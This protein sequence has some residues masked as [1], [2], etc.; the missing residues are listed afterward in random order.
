M[1]KIVKD[2]I[3]SVLFVLLF[4]LSLFAFVVVA[5]YFI[6]KT[7]HADVTQNLRACT[8]RVEKAT[9]S[10]V[11]GKSGQRYILTNWHVCQLFR[12]KQ[13]SLEA[14]YDDDTTVFGPI[15]VSDSSVDLCA[16]KITDQVPALQMTPHNRV[17][18][19][20]TRGYPGGLVNESHGYTKERIVWSY[21]LA[22][23]LIGTCPENSKVNYYQ[24]GKVRS[25]TFT[26][27]NILTNLYS[28]PGSSG[29][30]VLDNEGFLAGVISSH[31]SNLS[32][33][34]G[35]MVPTEDVRAFLDKL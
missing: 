18:D 8:V 26:W 12:A 24:N 21:E 29:S 23:E 5:S 17:K 22:V 33:F 1:K 25:C 2:A 15:V 16:A 28:R 10:I 9:G 30:P 3:L 27:T 20:V 11:F 32:D 34:A 7:A 14:V 4:S 6:T 35:G 13:K 19:V 31:D